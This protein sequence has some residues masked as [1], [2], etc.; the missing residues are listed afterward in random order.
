M[1]ITIQYKCIKFKLTFCSQIIHVL[2]FRSPPSV[3][4][5]PES[6]T[7]MQGMS[8]ELR[9]ISTGDPE[10]VLRWTKVRER[11]PENVMVI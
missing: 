11:I 9:C 3:R 6:Q 8:A 7:V 1:F 4:V 10:P 2:Y 5:E